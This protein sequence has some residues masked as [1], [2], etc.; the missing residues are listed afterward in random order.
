MPLAKACRKYQD[1]GLL[2][3]G[4]RAHAVTIDVLGGCVN[5][6]ISLFI[7]SEMSD[8][9]HKMTHTNEDQGNLGDQEASLTNE[10]GN[11]F[12]PIVAKEQLEEVYVDIEHPVKKRSLR[13]P[14]AGWFVLGGGLF[15]VVAIFLVSVFKSPSLK[16]ETM[17]VQQMMLNDV[18]ENE[19]EIRKIESYETTR[20]S[21]KQ[22][23]SCVR[24][25]YA[26]DQI[27]EKLK[28]VR[29]PDYVRGIMEGYY[30]Q[31]PIV[32]EEFDQLDKYSALVVDKVPFVYARVLMKSGKSHDVLLEQM[33][34]GSYKLDWE[35]E[36]HYQPLSW[37]DF[38]RQR[39]TKSYVMRVAVKPESFYVYQFRDGSKFDCYQLSARNSDRY[40]YG[41]V[42][43]GSELSIQLRRFF[44]RVKHL[45]KESSEP[46]M[47]E[48]RFPEV[49]S[50]AD[51]VHID[52]LV[53]PRWFLVRQPDTVPSPMETKAEER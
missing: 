47:L 5:N 4:G 46:M 51:C 35:S 53:A 20:R 3:F 6:A 28:Y 15:C 34:D 38:I 18:K 40:A 19:E 11:P 52:R 41:Y 50:K 25:Y 1:L 33:T 12:V 39:P 32:T 27:S 17:E 31:Q 36:V 10:E 13:V 22:I 49:G 14:A 9:Q 42:V 21:L 48:L 2:G 7:T 26:A 24:S 8:D 37:D 23:K 30:E 29:N 44:M 43:K 45:S 16:E